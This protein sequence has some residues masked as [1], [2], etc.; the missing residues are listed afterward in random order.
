MRHVVPKYVNLE[1]NKNTLM[2]NRAQRTC[3]T[4]QMMPVKKTLA[5]ALLQ[6]I[7]AALNLLVGVNSVVVSFWKL[8]RALVAI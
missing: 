6:M 3:V 1:Q 5:I 7:H 8:G 2:E 4:N